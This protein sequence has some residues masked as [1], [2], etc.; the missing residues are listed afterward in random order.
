M[1][2]V[3]D[4]RQQKGKHVTKHNWWADNS[5]ELFRSKIPFGDYCLPPK[6][7]VDTK[8]DIYEL[9][10][11]I[12]QDHKRFRD[13]CINAQKC[14]CQLVI[15]VENE[16]GVTGYE[17]LLKWNESHDHFQMRLRKSAKNCR[18]IKGQRL[19][20]ACLTMGKKYGVRFQF[21][22]PEESAAK[23]LELL[24]VEDEYKI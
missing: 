9:A 10:Q 12:D 22:R 21:C 20:K 11:D 13:E 3:E 2:L 18:L 24:E 6:L 15:L 4:S 19:A 8:K 5:V 7:A 23:V 1:W 16:D 17:S 14:G